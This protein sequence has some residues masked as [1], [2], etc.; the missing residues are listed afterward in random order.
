MNFLL[1]VK[2]QDGKVTGATEGRLQ[3]VN[4]VATWEEP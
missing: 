2:A 3:Q 1:A 4:V